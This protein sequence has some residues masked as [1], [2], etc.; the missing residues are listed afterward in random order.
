MNRLLCFAIVLLLAGCSPTLPPVA[1]EQIA[2]ESLKKFSVH[3]KL[4]LPL[5]LSSNL[6][7]QST[8]MIKFARVALRLLSTTINPGQKN[9]L[10][11]NFEVKLQVHFPDSGS[12]QVQF[13]IRSIR[14]RRSSSFNNL[15]LQYTIKSII[16]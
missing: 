10:G 3:G 11:W 12:E 1:D 8:S 7:L 14:T 6:S 15:V 2:K 4:V 5:I 13:L 9:G 16:E